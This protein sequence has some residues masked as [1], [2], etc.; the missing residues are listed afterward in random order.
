M[1]YVDGKRIEGCIVSEDRAEI[2]QM[3][4]KYVQDNFN[5]K[6]SKKNWHI[7]IIEH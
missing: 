7:K 1:W 4:N 5:K 6:I 3:A 2:N